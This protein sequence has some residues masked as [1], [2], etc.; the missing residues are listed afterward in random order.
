MKAASGSCHW[1]E[2][3]LFWVLCFV[4]IISCPSVCW[5]NISIFFKNERLWY[6]SLGLF[7]D[8]CP[9][10]HQ[11]LQR[12]PPPRPMGSG[13][14]L[15]SPL[16]PSSIDPHTVVNYRGL[17]VACGSHTESSRRTGAVSGPVNSFIPQNT[18]YN[19]L[20]RYPVSTWLLHQAIMHQGAAGTLLPGDTDHG[21][22]S[23]QW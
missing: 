10:L 23:S 19:L 4:N 7:L 20:E 18:P 16:G 2:M 9:H 5:F 3:T 21:S 22:W 8:N 6:C 14:F 1:K 13:P 15:M 12:T 11:I 17:S